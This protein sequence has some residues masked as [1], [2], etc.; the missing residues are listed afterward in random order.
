[1]DIAIFCVRRSEMAF[2][3]RI[4]LI[5]VVIL[6]PIA[7]LSQETVTL[8]DLEREA[9]AAN[10]EIAMAARKADAAKERSSLA[11]ALPDPM[12]GVEYQN[13]G[14]LTDPTIGEEEMSMA[15]IV[16]TQEIPFPGKLSTRGNAAEKAAAREEENLRETRLRVLS[17]LR[18]AY[19]DYALAFRATEILEQ[20]KEI[21]RN[22][23]RIAETRYATGQGIQQDA[24][25]AQIEV[26]MILD[27]LVEQQQKKEAG[28]AMINSLT[29]RDPRSPLGRP[30]GPVRTSVETTLDELSSMALAHSPVLGAKQRM[31]E[32]GEYEVSSSKR[33]FLPDMTVSAGWFNRGDFKDVW[34]A[35]V[36]LKVPLYFWNKTTG[37]RAAKE[38]LGAARHEYDATR[39][40]LLSRIRDLYSTAKA[41]EH[42]ISLYESAIIPQ[43]RMALQSAASSYQV[44][45][46]DF[47]TLVEAEALVLKYQL[48]YEKELVNLNKT[49]AVMG[50]MVG[51]GPVPGTGRITQ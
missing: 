35:S 4:G 3:T 19:Y 48:A 16:F 28:A 34:T 15:G 10:P 38:E 11:S 39:L 9:L 32:Q 14:R 33:E 2:F 25:R 7:A 12:I 22:F 24:L 36:M 43:A 40:M 29:G 45:K 42:H 31:V 27:E 20:N 51:E 30:A 13:V 23:Q 1:V 46:V 49:I 6:M 18:S 47:M 44:G 5:L 26:S 21:M 37:V 17:S 41:S 50:E 8:R